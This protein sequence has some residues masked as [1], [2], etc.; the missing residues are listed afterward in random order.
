MSKIFIFLSFPEEY[1]APLNAYRL[2]IKHFLSFKDYSIS[3]IV[4]FLFIA[5]NYVI[6]SFVSSIYLFKYYLIFYPDFSNSFGKLNFIVYILY[7]YS[8]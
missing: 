8:I 7:F 6:S 1:A 3:L 4:S 5:N 2:Q